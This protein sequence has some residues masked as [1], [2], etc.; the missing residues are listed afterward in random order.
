M[1]DRPGLQ[2]LRQRVATVVALAVS[3]TLLL[4]LAM[5]H[6]A[7]EAKD[8]EA[9]DERLVH[10]AQ[11]VMALSKTQALKPSDQSG[12]AAE[13]QSLESSE[14]SI[15]HFQVWSP[16]GQ[17]LLRSP[18]VSATAAL[19]PLS[20]LGLHVNQFNGAPARV[21]A[22]RDPLDGRVIQ[23]VDALHGRD[24][25][26]SFY[27]LPLI[28][29]FLV[30][31]LVTSYLIRRSF[32]T[33]DAMAAQ[34]H[35]RHLLDVKPMELA[36]SP[37]EF[38]PMVNA[39]NAM[40]A[41]AGKA[42]SMEQSFT[43]LAA[44]ELRTPWA[45]IRAQAQIASSSNSKD[46]LKQALQT[47]I[48]GIDR[49]SHV[50]DQLLD[51]ARIETMNTDVATC[52]QSVKLATCLNQVI[53]DLSGL[54]GKQQIS[55]VSELSSEVVQGLDFIIYLMLRNLVS[56][57]ILYAPSGGR[58]EV[59][60]MRQF[61][62]LVLHVDDSGEGISAEQRDKAFERFNRLGQRGSDGVGLGLSIVAQ[63]AQLLRAEIELTQSPLGGLRAAVHF[64]AA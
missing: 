16:D 41:R 10:A 26:Y 13:V 62:H 51:L 44:H 55:V 50:L 52:F 21:L 36:Q 38:V 58:V 27:L 17:L 24:E 34:M 6:W 29:P 49:A 32:R 39:M 42:L 20:T 9:F 4:S 56:N 57:A 63:A 61:G 5:V 35:Q 48:R 14:A 59:S 12:A 11:L 7:E 2:P 23:M 46:E 28:L 1:P 3:G 43:S 15:Y 8:E 54:A 31:L 37:Q 22:L 18:H 40:F 64:P 45:G 30:S 47:M 33:V 53:E 60:A 25:N 19:L